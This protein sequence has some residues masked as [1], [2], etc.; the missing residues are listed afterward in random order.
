MGKNCAPHDRDFMGNWVLCFVFYL[1]FHFNQLCFWLN[2]KK[3]TWE[4]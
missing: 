1:E 2:F 4:W 3:W